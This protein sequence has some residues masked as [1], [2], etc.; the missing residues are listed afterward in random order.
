M[1]CCANCLA[2]DYEDEIVGKKA[3][4][5]LDMLRPGTQRLDENSV[6]ELI[7]SFKSA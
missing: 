7:T 4:V 1:P 5:F 6:F 3:Q 2:V